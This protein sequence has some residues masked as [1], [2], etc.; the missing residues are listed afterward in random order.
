MAEKDKNENKV[1]IAKSSDLIQKP[2][3]EVLHDSMIPYAEHVI[4]DR[5][6]P[7]VE[8]GLKPVQRRILYAMYDMGITPDKPYRK[9]A[10][11]VGECLGKYHPH[12][13]SSVYD[14]MVRM[15]QPFNMSMV[16]VDG[17]G[18]FGSVD[19]DS[20][21]AM[22]YTEARLAPLALEL[23]RDID[24]ETVRFSLNF[25]DTTKEPDMLPGRFPNLLV[26]GA[27]GI[28]VGLATNIP[29]HNLAEVIDG[30]TAMIDNPD[31]T[32]KQMMKII[33]GPD[34]PT[35]G[36]VVA[37]DLEK[38]YETGRGKVLI[39]AKVSIESDANEKKNIVIHELPFQVNKARLLEKILA[40]KEEKKDQLAGIYD[41]CDE[42]DRNGMRAVIKVRKD[43]D[44]KEILKILFKSTDLETSFGINMVAIADGK[45]Q[46]MG[47]LDILYY[48]INYQREVILKRTRF[49]LA[50]AKEREHILEGLLI[51]VRNIDEVIRII[52]SS[53]N[54]GEA[55]TRLRERF[56]LSER[57]A[58]AILDMRLARL[59]S[60]E[61]YKLEQELK[62][63]QELIRYLQGI[64]D[65]KKKQLQV[66]KDELYE[67]KR[68]YKENRRTAVI[69]SV[70]DIEISSDT[71]APTV[72]DF[73]VVCNANGSLKR[74]PA[75]N[76]GMSNRT[77]SERATL[78][79]V[80]VCLAETRSDRRL[81]LFTNLGNC[82]KIEVSDL[83]E[84]RW[85]EKGQPLKALV[86]SAEEGERAVAFFP[87]G[88]TFPTG[89]LLFFTRAG[90]VKKTEWA[91]YD[92]VRNSFQAI[93]LKE[94]D[95]LIGVEQDRPDT[96]LLFITAGGFCLHAEKGDLPVQGRVAGGVH[97]INLNDFDETLYAGQADKKTQ[98]FAVTEKGYFKKVNL[99][100]VEPIARYR[101][102]V[103]LIDLGKDNGLRLSFAT[104][105]EKD[106]ETEI[107]LV[108]AGDDLFVVNAKE[109]AL[110][111]RTGKGKTVK[112]YRKGVEVRTGFRQLTEGQ[113]EPP[114]PETGKEGENK[115]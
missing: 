48:Y 105:L 84:C 11:I 93:K 36:Y 64:L 75:K 41:I 59:T 67:I 22:R 50:E 83:P 91:E 112:E 87:V 65:S 98:M 18:N 72:G 99:S 101:K 28:A 113:P 56:A 23:L 102:G 15:A 54:V 57:Q 45:P 3:E 111:Q 20:A 10:R 82:H 81:W 19:G 12:G 103:K 114:L 97:G 29:P 34:F 68:K 9:S 35:G 42:S 79:E 95:E 94:G 25:D 31:I 92:V 69:G 63:V 78:N 14:A 46:Q 73:A 27:Y 89:H 49:Q 16:L 5:A 60:L 106:K 86:P 85:R 51:A 53:A 17:H 26:N 24:K 21:A 39:R 100:T 110:E 77:I 107:C 44:P 58:N 2:L 55:R 61:I 96:T 8:D 4:L 33:K 40:L 13:D 6:L 88:E 62:E 1:E 71:D 80:A 32:L 115:E 76:F 104:A 74:V 38:A 37:T 52:K 109:V 7:R 66:I 43:A 30:V 47:L 108:T 70:D 90:Y